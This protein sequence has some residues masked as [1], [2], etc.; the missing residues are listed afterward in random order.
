[1]LRGS[2]FEKVKAEL[3]KRLKGE[4]SSTVERF[5]EGLLKAS[6]PDLP[7]LATVSDTGEMAQVMFN[8][9]KE[10]SPKEIKV[11]VRPGPEGTTL[12]MSC[13]EDQPFIVDTI[14]LYLE[15][16][17][18]EH[19]FV[20]HPILR[21][22]RENGL[23]KGIGEG[24]IAESINLT[25]VES[26]LCSED[27]AALAQEVKKVLTITRDVVNDFVRMKRLMRIAI[28]DIEF[29]GEAG[30]VPMEEVEEIAALLEWALDNK[31]V[32]LGSIEVE[33]KK[34]GLKF[35]WDTGLGVCRKEH[36]DFE[37]NCDPSEVEELLVSNE[38]NLAVAS[39]L[40]AESTI[41]RAGKL[42]L[43]AVQMAPDESGESKG[44]YVFVGLLTKS[45]VLE[46][47]TEVPMVRRKLQ[48]VAQRLEL[49]PGTHTYREAVGI[50]NTIPVE[51]LFLYDVE[52][53][54]NVLEGVLGLGK[55][56][57][58]K[59]FVVEGGKGIHSIL[60]VIPQE[61]YSSTLE[62]EIEEF[63]EEVFQ[64]TYTYSTFS[65]MEGEKAFIHYF[66]STPDEE[67]EVST[68][69][70][71]EKVRELS[72]TW[73]DRLYKILQR[74]IGNKKA[75]E[76]F[77]RYE[78]TF[79]DEYRSLFSPQK[80]Y[81]DLQMIERL[82]ETK[83]L[84]VGI[85]E[86]KEG[87]SHIT[88]FSPSALIL[89]QTVPILGHLFLKVLDEISID[90]KLKGGQKVYLHAFRVLQS[91]GEPLPQEVPLAEALIST[92]TGKVES[93]PMNQLVVKAALPWEVVDLLRTYRNYLRQIAPAYTKASI[94]NAFLEY[95]EITSTIW[96]Y[97]DAKFN[98]EREESIED[99]KEGL[100]Q[101]VKDIFLK[102]LDKVQDLASD[103]IFRIFF[104]LVESTLRTNF[105]KSSRSHHYISIKIDCKS[106]LEMPLPRPMFEIYVHEVGMEGIHLRGGK[107]AR[108]G[109]RWSD[110]PDD[111]RTEI[112][113][114]M[115]TQMV[116]NAI[117]VPT[118]SKG[119]FIIKVRGRDREE[120]NRLVTEKYTVLM[121]GMLDITDN[122]VDGKPV[123]PDEVVCY[124]GY[125]PYLVVAADKGTAHLS[126]TAN[127]ISQ[128]YG[129]WLDD[130]FASGGSAGYDHKKLGITAKGA[131]V[132]TRR[133]FMEMGIDPNKDN[134][135]VVGIGD[136]G[137]DVFG[138]G[139]L[140]SQSI[141]LV[142]AFNHIHI[143]MDP[144]P[145]PLTSW[146]ERERLF[147]A[148]KGWDHYNEELIS[149]GGGVFSRQAKSVP[150]SPQM[151]KILGT[152]KS[153]AS[154]EEVIRMLLKAPVD[155]LWNGG[156]GT[157][158][159]SSSETHQDVGDHSNDNVRIDA[160]QLR[161]K[162]VGEGGNLGFTQKAR[163]EYALHGGA[164]YTDALDNSAGVDMS[165]H[166]V[167]LKILF[168]DM[169]KKNAMTR[170]E[171]NR[172]L[173]E[174]TPEVV[175]HVLRH[176]Y[177]QS[178][179]VSLDSIRS[180][181]DTSPFATTVEMLIREQ[182]FDPSETV[183]PSSTEL[184]NR[185]NAGEGLFKPELALL[186]GHVKRWVKR[187]LE[188]CQFIDAPYLND[189][190]ASYFP[191]SLREKF[192]DAIEKH[193]LRR[194]ILITMITNRVVNQAGQSFFTSL[195]AEMG[196][197]VGEA[198]A[199]Y[200]VMDGIIEAPAIREEICS[201]DFKVPAEV[202]YQA[203]ISLDNLVGGLVRWALL[204]GGDWM[205][206]KEVIAK[207]NRQ[208]Y[209]LMDELEVILTPEA[210]KECEATRTELEKHGLSKK[211]ATL[212][213]AAR[214]AVN[215][216]DVL[217]LAETL[218]T[219]KVKELAVIY[220]E[221]MERFQFFVVQDALKEDPKTS[222][223][224]HQAYTMLE[225]D[226][227]GIKRTLASQLY[228]CYQEAGTTKAMWKAHRKA[229]PTLYTYLSE[230][231]EGVKRRHAT[232]L[233]V[234]SVVLRRIQET[235]Q[236]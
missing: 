72:T 110:R 196:T 48:E 146:K 30:L 219:S 91:N 164:I 220:T 217:T 56:F 114:L 227:W 145:D 9:F 168:Q 148:G 8:F 173:E 209:G 234:W 29:R 22:I 141:K 74:E 215:F 185:N 104:N 38:E 98:P 79:S 69:E 116:K 99:R 80:A 125:D 182:L 205:P 131:W 1:M 13:L 77:A 133:H 67:R 159:K 41:H 193:L 6:P 169:L 228:Q 63:L 44:W 153:E 112:L 144:D 175:T 213:S 25:L 129:F 183:V 117:I 137:G 90:L 216:M 177:E 127:S 218:E 86:D 58:P 195:Q 223:W 126:D 28:S 85:T 31:F 93:D 130:A 43:L 47:G 162:V 50:F 76:L 105:Y 92:I 115:K 170:D 62:E 83:E 147:K 17:G 179:A 138:N 106:I 188:E 180:K 160:N 200:M 194:E 73:E 178:L 35:K 53:L 37:D 60:V 107:V 226:L 152:N 57:E 100:I 184:A 235:L 51:A 232:G 119:G 211:S 212:L 42:D 221:M 26:S 231:A 230:V 5:V 120:T 123:H 172:L 36:Q 206:L 3:V 201:L 149:E 158:V 7:E 142:G 68:E 75:A 33:R 207:Y 199:A 157:Y 97:F 52:H 135:T 14:T 124:D 19:R 225:K 155:L 197:S 64:A 118:G 122:V 139:M 2:F 95:P 21:A 229:N 32:F 208:V 65:S 34:K 11:D 198:A 4:G 143:F 233:A 49:S 222:L 61:R 94:Y 71:E 150:I 40:D 23:L 24:G 165:D 190:L 167:N 87:Y 210:L 156:I 45:A 108:G 89:S 82:L 18:Y 20:L 181:R 39:K 10:R 101:E 163:V 154:G 171:R 161:C 176:N 128:S 88:I 224:E 189:L 174:L 15:K 132:N 103:K 166:E 96:D 16:K 140:L 236:A 113:G 192:R 102:Q 121:S 136:M 66:I 202:Q 214:Y 187:E 59:A 84:Q 54:T 27:C 46:K 78:G 134:I 186:L 81:Q 151:Q 70:I 191:H 203:L 55:E 111:F 12:V 204:F 109:I